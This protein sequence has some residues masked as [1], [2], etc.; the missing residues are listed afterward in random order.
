MSKNAEQHLA[1]D[2][3]IY[4]GDQP[5][6]PKKRNGL[7]RTIHFQRYQ[8]SDRRACIDPGSALMNRGKIRQIRRRRFRQKSRQ[9]TRKPHNRRHMLRNSF[10]C[11]QLAFSS[12]E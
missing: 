10:V 4:L 2:H 12:S 11:G 1:A 8:D 3:R 9:K 5:S 7:Y 6:W